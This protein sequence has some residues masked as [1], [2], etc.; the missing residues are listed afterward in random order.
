MKRRKQAL[1]LR[2]LESGRWLMIV[3]IGEAG[4]VG[5]TEEMI[6]QAIVEH[7][8]E[9]TSEWIRNQLNYLEDKGLVKIEKHEVK[10]WRVVL[11]HYGHDV[12]DYVVPVPLGIRRPSVK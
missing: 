2:H 12:R 3:A 9:T 8:P 7:W 5:A 6:L 11:A 10:Q 1:R 4:Y